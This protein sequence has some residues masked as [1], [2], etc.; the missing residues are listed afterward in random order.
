LTDIIIQEFFAFVKSFPAGFEIALIYKFNFH[1]SMEK[2]KILTFFER[3]AF[4]TES[5]RSLSGNSLQK[6]KKLPFL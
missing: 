2:K 1:F 5:C 6:K 3:N 4:L